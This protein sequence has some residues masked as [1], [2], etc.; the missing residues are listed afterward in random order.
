M[1]KLGNIVRVNANGML[2]SIRMI[3]TKLDQSIVITVIP[4][5]NGWKPFDLNQGEYQIQNGFPNA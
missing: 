3:T 5:S 1:V 4:I 2:A